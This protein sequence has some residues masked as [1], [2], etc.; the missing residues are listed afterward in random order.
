[1]LLK[2][3]VV[4]DDRL[5]RSMVREVFEQEGHQ[6]EEAPDGNVALSLLREHRPDLLVIDLLMPD[7]G[8]LEMIREAWGLLP[9]LPIIAMSGGASSISGQYLEI[10]EGFEA[11]RLLGK[12]FQV[13]ELL[14][15]VEEACGDGRRTTEEGKTGL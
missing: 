1:M 9:T 6:V 4:G 12:P 10:A 8:G 13:D 3:L 15:A 2:L 14:R 11:V 7:K 5:I